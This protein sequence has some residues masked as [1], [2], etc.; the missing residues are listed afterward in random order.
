MKGILSNETVIKRFRKIHGDKYD[1]SK[2]VY[3]GGNIPIIIICPEHGEFEKK[4]ILHCSGTGCFKCELERRSK[5][6]RLP[7]NECIQR[8]NEKYN[9]R[10]GYEKLHYTNAHDD[11]IVTCVKHGDFVTCLDTHLRRGSNCP[12][13]QQEDSPRT[14]YYSAQFERDPLLA[15]RPGAFY[16]IKLS[17]DTECFYKVGITKNNVATRYHQSGTPGYKREVIMEQS[18]TLYEAFKYEQFCKEHLETYV[19]QT[20]FD[21]YTECV[22][23]WPYEHFSDLQIKMEQRPLL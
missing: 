15:N 10:Y 7:L 22:V 13:C 2:M 1:Y 12:K 21:G 18:M 3:K 20:K 17:N 9:G 4:P 8:L 19:P 5:K 16:V 6:F 11:V 14:G 23:E